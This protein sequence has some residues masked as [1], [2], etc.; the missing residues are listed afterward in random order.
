MAQ[1]LD[2]TQLAQVALNEVD[3]LVTVGSEGVEVVNKSEYATEGELTNGL[4]GKVDK[5]E[6]K[7]LSTNDYTDAD[8]AKLENL[9]SNS[10]LEAALNDK[11][12][13]IDGKGLSSNDF[14]NADKSKLNSLENYD[15]SSVVARLSDIES[16][17]SGWNAKY[18]KPANG[19]PKSDLT[20]GIQNTLDSVAN[21]QDTLQSGV[22]IKTI[23]DQ[24]I[25][26]SGNIVIEGGGGSS[27]DIID[28]LNSERTDAA[29]SANQGRVL[30]GMI[31]SLTGYATETWVENKN[32]LTSSDISGK[33]DKS[34]VDNGLATKQDTLVSGTNVKTINNE[35]ILGSGNIVISGGDPTP[36]VDSLD[37]TSTTSALSANQGKVLKGYVDNTYTKSEVDNLLSPITEVIPSEATSSNQLADKAFVNSS[38]ATNTA[39]FIDTFANITA[40]N[41]YSGTVTNNDYAFVV[42]SVVSTDFVDVTALNAYDKTLLTNFD[43]G[44]VINGSKFDLYRFDIINQEWVLRVQNTDKASVTLNTA[45]NRYKASVS[46]NTVTWSFEYTLNNSSF[47]AAQWAAINSG[48]TTSK[49]SS[50]DSEIAGK[51]DTIAD[52]SDIRS[53]ASAGSTAVQPAALNDYAPKS[54][55]VTGIAYNSSTKKLEK[56]INGSTTDVVEFGDNAFTSTAI[57]TKVSD[58]DNDSGFIT[59]IN[60][61]DVTTALGYTP[62]NSSNPNGYTSNTGTVTSVN[63]VQPVDGNVTI[64]IPAAVDEQ[65]VSGWGFTKNAGTITGITMNSESVGTSGV[66][67]LGTVVTQETDPVFSASAAATI[68]SSDIS[69]W[70]GKTSNVGTITG[71]TMNGVSK[72]TSGVVD[73]GTVITQHQDISGKE[74]ISNK[75]TSLSAQSTDTQYPSAKCVYDLVG[76]IESLLANI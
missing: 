16:K 48:I 11:V 57:P 55:A 70:N 58:L 33:A 53:G 31:P 3:S 13:K 25:L 39:N 65:T 40:L 73:L 46:S 36:V 14:T 23:N 6:G 42:N 71:I 28:D 29:L 10:D 20:Q 72:G 8:K 76:N 17:E 19:I 47:T 38:I 64:S 9:P 44:W 2:I 62:Y 32:Y 35:S 12:D 69:N 24:S 26:G 34:Y 15:D 41:S 60:S 68:T 5:I 51:Q 4:A 27:V 18:S 45:Y 56:T 21:K 74:N 52:L 1:Y 7:G 49:I 67:N 50:I 61:S 43:Y 59:G 30:K 22:N 66:V 37:S 75:V 63:N 54:T